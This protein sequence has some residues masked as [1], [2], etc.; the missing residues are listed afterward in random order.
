MTHHILVMNLS[1]ATQTLHEGTRL[2]GIYPVES[3][4]HVEEMLWVESDLSD[5]ESD[6]DDLTDARATGIA[7]KSASVKT[8]RANACDDVR[9]DPKDLPEHLQPFMEWI[10]E[11]ITT[12][13]HEELAAAIYEY[14]DVFSSGPEDIRQTDLVTHTIDTGDHRPIRLPPR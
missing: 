11:H 1:D 7:S 12:R 10:S 3:F 8:P 6:N 9:M 5:W 4:K 13:V 2:G 14:R